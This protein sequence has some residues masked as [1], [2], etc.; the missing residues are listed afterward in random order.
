[1]PRSKRARLV[2]LTKTTKRATREH[3]SEFVQEVRNAVDNH[4]QL[5]LFSYENMRSSKFKDIRMHFRSKE[6]DDGMDMP[7]KIML[8]KNKL[9]QISLGRTPEDEYA[10]NLRHVAKE[11][12]ESVGVLFTSRPRSEVE[13]YFANF[14][15]PDFARAGF[16][17]PR[18]VFITNEMLFNHPV[19]MVEQQF[20]KQGLPVKIDNG[21]IVLLDG[22]TQYRLCKEGE[23]LSP[24]K[25]KALTHFGIKLSEFKVK[26]VCRWSGGEFEKLD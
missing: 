26:L 5:Y 1:M 17:S 2:P 19:S 8:G 18:D 25:C 12:T 11:I 24:D 16:V 6:G 23:T 20:R 9:L 7:S 13:E 3:K 4:E 21:K 15:E 10:D 14:V 22:L